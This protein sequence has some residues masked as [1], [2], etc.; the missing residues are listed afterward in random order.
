MSEAS[1]DLF[2]GGE[3]FLRLCRILIEAHVSDDVTFQR[4]SDV[5]DGFAPVLEPFLHPL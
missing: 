1:L 3:W 4:M 2:D 5:E